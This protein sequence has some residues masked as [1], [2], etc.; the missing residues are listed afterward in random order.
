MITNNIYIVDKQDT[1]NIV[2]TTG[3]ILTNFHFK[4]IYAINDYIF[5]SYNNKE[6]IYFTIDGKILFKTKSPNNINYDEY[7]NCIYTFQDNNILVYNDK[8]IF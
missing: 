7:K 4:N 3:K 6:V 1:A 2:D 8:E 5:K